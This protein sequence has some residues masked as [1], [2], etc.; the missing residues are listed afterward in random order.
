[1]RS[2]P[3]LLRVSKVSCAVNS[4]NV[5]ISKLVVVYGQI[6]SPDRQRIYETKS[7]E[8]MNDDDLQ[9]SFTGVR[10]EYKFLQYHN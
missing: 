10:R 5:V 8:N 9:N 2:S 1:M 6:L 4:E 7:Q 3:T